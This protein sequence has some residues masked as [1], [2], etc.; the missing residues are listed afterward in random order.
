MD[1]ISFQAGNMLVGNQVETE[2]IEL[3]VPPCAPS[4]SKPL[5][6]VAHFHVDAIAAVT[7]AATTIT[8]DGQTKNA[9]SSFSVPAG[10]KLIINGAIGDS[11][12]GGGLR[13][14]LTITGGLPGIPEYLGSKS[15]SMGFGGYQVSHILELHFTS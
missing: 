4:L 12:Q 15:T 6:F 5:A 2:A 7:G 9:W 1:P 10:S 8:V 13:A 3:V 11:S 14:Y